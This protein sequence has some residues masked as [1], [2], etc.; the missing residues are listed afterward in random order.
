MLI[1]KNGR[2]YA[3]QSS[4]ALP[5]GCKVNDAP[6]AAYRN[7]INLCTEDETCTIDVNF[8]YGVGGAKESIEDSMVSEELAD[9]SPKVETRTYGGITCWCI[10]YEG[11]LHRYFESRFDAPTGLKDGDG[12][13]INIFRMVVTAPH[14][15]NIKSIRHKSEI[16]GLLKSFRP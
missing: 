12:N 1:C 16:V 8:E 3:G 9:L 11:D 5:D 13:D 6:L 2:L 10:E 15:S 7:G 14:D 4:F